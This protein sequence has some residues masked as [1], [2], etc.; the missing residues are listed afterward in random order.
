MPR[1]TAFQAGIAVAAKPSTARH[2]VDA[3]SASPGAPA[4]PRNADA[5]IRSQGDHDSSDRAQADQSSG[6]GQL[7]EQQAS[8]IRAECE[9]DA[10]LVGA[11]LNRLADE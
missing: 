9:A 2:V 7:T 11:L 3:A 1:C 6:S 5:M 10:E 8:G 4:K